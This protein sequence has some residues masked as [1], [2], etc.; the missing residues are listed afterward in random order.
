MP[1][2]TVCHQPQGRAPPHHALLQLEDVSGALTLRGTK[3]RNGG[4]RLTEDA[5]FDSAQER[6]AGGSVVQ[7]AA[8]GALVFFGHG[9]DGTT[10]R[11]EEQAWDGLGGIGEIP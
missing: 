7:Q 10:A 9:M 4:K 6:Q 5:D 2:A 3:D 8:V 11:V 1:R